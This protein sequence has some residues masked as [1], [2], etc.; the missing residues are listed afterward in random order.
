MEDKAPLVTLAPE[1][2][3][4]SRHFPD[5][6]RPIFVP[7]DFDFVGPY[8]TLVGEIGIPASGVSTTIGKENVLEDRGARRLAPSLESVEVPIAGPELLYRF[9]YPG[10][11]L[12]VVGQ[13]KIW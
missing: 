10:F 13:H 5:P 3:R 8:L 9:Y 6:V 7:V 2:L 11:F 4:H 1:I 12:A